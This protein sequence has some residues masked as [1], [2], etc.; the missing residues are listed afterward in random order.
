MKYYISLLLVFSS[1]SAQ[2][3]LFEWL[4]LKSRQEITPEVLR[5]FSQNTWKRSAQSDQKCPLNVGLKEVPVHSSESD[6]VDSNYKIEISDE[7]GKTD[8]EESYV[9]LLKNG[10]IKKQK[11]CQVHAEI[12]KACAEVKGKIKDGVVTLTLKGK[13]KFNKENRKDIGVNSMGVKMEVKLFPFSEN[14]EINTTVSASKGP[15]GII[16]GGIKVKCR[17]DKVSETANAQVDLDRS[18][19]VGEPELS[20]SANE[21]EPSAASQE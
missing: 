3:G 17:Y 6:E 12:G 1:V 14:I 8:D 2:A 15:L 13:L 16:S 4:G 5:S 10:K 11:E 9:S 18:T 19:V 20:P 21:S 7:A